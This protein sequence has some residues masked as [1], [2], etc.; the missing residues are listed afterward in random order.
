MFICF[1]SFQECKRDL[2]EA[3]LKIKY[4]KEG[5]LKVRCE[6]DIENRKTIY[7]IYK[8]LI[9]T[10]CRAVIPDTK[11]RGVKLDECTIFKSAVS[12]RLKLSPCYASIF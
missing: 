9:A 6:R 3:M 4:F 12:V 7:S 10:Y 8:L 2:F 5:Y 1:L 11:K